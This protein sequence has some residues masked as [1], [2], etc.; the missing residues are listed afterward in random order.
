MY[1]FVVK[2]E[3][4][5]S[6]LC[7]SATL[8][9]NGL[10]MASGNVIPTKAATS[11]HYCWGVRTAVLAVASLITFTSS[12]SAKIFYG[13]SPDGGGLVKVVDTD[14]PDF[15]AKPPSAAASVV[16]FNGITWTI[17][18]E[19]VETNSNVGFGHATY[20]AQR[21]ARLE[22]ALDL[23]SSY[24]NETGSLD[25]RA[26]V[27]QTDGLGSLAW[28]GTYYWETPAFTGGM[29]FD[30]IQTGSD[31]AP[32]LEDIYL[33]VDFGHN[34]YEGTGDP[35]FFEYHLISVL[36]HEITNGLGI[37][38]LSNASGASQIVPGVYTLWDELL[39]R[40]GVVRDLFDL[41]V[42]TPT[43]LGSAPDL[44]SDD[45]VFTGTEATATY[46]SSPPVHSPDPFNVGSNLSHFDESLTAV[47]TPL[48][49]NGEVNRE[50]ADFEIDALVDIGWTNASAGLNVWVD[51][52]DVVGPW[53]GTQSDPFNTLAD[54]ISF[55]AEGGT[56]Y[57][58]A[59]QTSE[60]VSINT[61]M[62]IEAVGGLVRIG[63]G[64]MPA[65]PAF[66]G[67]VPADV[68]RAG[69]RL[70]D[71]VETSSGTYIPP[72]DT[73]TV[74]FIFETKRGATQDGHEVLRGIGLDADPDGP[75]FDDKSRF[76]STDAVAVQRV[77][78]EALGI[79]TD[80]DC[81][82]DDNDVTN[83][84]DIQLAINKVLGF[85]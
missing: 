72:D 27:S 20:G 9:G 43:F 59:G 65:K 6:S 10:P 25:V 69:S 24:L 46:G 22:N 36:V 37:A 85:E 44:I 14:A 33:T 42:G 12:A 45:V 48:I 32:E 58:A 41:V 21:R 11:A 18:Y 31:P 66:N 57:I 63:V 51:F 53:L 74:L 49:T 50:Y 23:I 2:K 1:R 68:D 19:D 56:I 77:I 67:I 80:F 13:Y 82:I 35:G 70:T 34:W 28:A 47:M 60:I 4:L 39:E 71:G 64:G 40:G 83:V 79:D 26:A 52:D 16:T 73:D 78:S 62:R 54:A 3:W 5:S 7:A 17:T 76:S 30:H 61:A 15:R 84:V 55:V 81:D 75:A 8:G 38:S 29:A